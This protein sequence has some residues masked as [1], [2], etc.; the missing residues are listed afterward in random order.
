MKEKFKAR[1][2]VFILLSIIF[3]FGTISAAAAPSVVVSTP[4][5]TATPVRSASPSAAPTASGAS[6]SSTPAP[7]SSAGT[8]AQPSEPASP[9]DALNAQLICEAAVLI[10]G[11]SG[12]VLYE[13][14]A[15]ERLYP[16][17]T[18]KIATAMVALE[19]VAA[20][21]ASLDDMV[22]TYGDDLSELP[23]DSSVL[24]LLDGEEM[25][26]GDLLNGLL[27]ASGND[28]AIVIARYIGGSQEAF[29]E[30]MNALMQKVGAENSHFEN[31]HGL[32]S[33]NH[34]TT[35]ADMAKLTKY[36]MQNNTFRDYV[37]NA[38]I[39]L[40]VTNKSDRRYFINTNNLISRMRFTDFYYD[41]AIGVKTGSTDQAGYC[42]I[43]A[44]QSGE[45]ELISVVLKSDDQTHS[46]TSSKALLEYGFDNFTSYK[47]AKQGEILSEVRIKY[48]AGGIDHIPLVPQTA[49]ALTIPKGANKDEIEMEISAPDF[50]AAPVEIDQVIGSVSY[51]Y[52]GQILNTVP[53]VSDATVPRHALGFIFQGIDKIWGIEAVRVVIYILIAAAFALV[54]IFIVGLIRALGKKNKRSSSRPYEPPTYYKNNRKF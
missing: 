24:G 1:R 23:A 19:A 48:A 30:R 41:K 8:E 34:Y 22:T 50:V 46:H 4:E 35:A 37:S 5:P 36:A 42:L 25:P 32:H 54:F 12:A 49:V 15:N 38:H 2:F 27:V 7:S 21:E 10:D 47:V 53:L 44:A 16:A 33:D 20:G 52:H 17:S 9:L 39:Y 13:K 45:R 6:A 29:V 26:L 18:T 28:A 43:A 3:L 11:K 31:A 51:K 14:N 40:P